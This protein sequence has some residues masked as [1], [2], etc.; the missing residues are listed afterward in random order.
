MVIAK[1]GEARGS[2][3]E[4]QW[5]NGERHGRGTSAN[6]SLAESFKGLEVLTEFLAVRM[7]SIR[8]ERMPSD[9]RA[10][11]YTASGNRRESDSVH[12]GV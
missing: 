11:Y 8:P 5:S 2:R 7:F 3:Y 4:G 1:D 10:R 6:R 12:K 9:L